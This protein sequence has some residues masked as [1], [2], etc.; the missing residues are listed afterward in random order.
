M[1]NPAVMVAVVL[2]SRLMLSCDQRIPRIFQTEKSTTLLRTQDIF[3][4]YLKG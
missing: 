4:K 2:L 1:R 3:K